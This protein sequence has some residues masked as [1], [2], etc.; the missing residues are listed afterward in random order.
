MGAASVATFHCFLPRLSPQTRANLEHIRRTKATIGGLNAMG[1]SLTWD[2]VVTMARDSLLRNEVDKEV[3]HVV[4]QE[5]PAA[6]PKAASAAAP[7]A[8][9]PPPAAAHSAPPC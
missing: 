4:A 3:K 6:T 7:V 2:E 5:A 9:P 1:G 8:A